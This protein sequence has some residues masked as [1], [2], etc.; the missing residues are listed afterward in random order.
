M[1]AIV[2]VLLNTGL[3]VDELVRLV[4]S[5]A[6]LQPRSGKAFIQPGKGHKARVV[7]LN[8]TVREAFG[9]DSAVDR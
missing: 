1:D 2:T 9:S 5:D 8:A 4:W 7:P 3:R 6:T